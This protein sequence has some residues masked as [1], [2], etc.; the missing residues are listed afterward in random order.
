MIY[1][2]KGL[3]TIVTTL[4]IILLVLVAIG[5]IWV[6]IRGVVEQ[7]TSQIDINTKCLSVDVRATAAKCGGTNCWV[8]VTKKTGTEAI[9]GVAFVFR[10]DTA[11]SV[12]SSPYIN[13]T[14]DIGLLSSK[15]VTAT[16]LANAD[17]VD[18]IVYFNDESGVARL[19]T[20]VNSFKF[21]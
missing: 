11:G 20:Q 3:S 6:V 19:C 17:T 2:K 14:G 21:A 10:N 9:N 15:N 1:N 12:S 18:V 4:I 5:I 16:G 13:A 7:G 8:M